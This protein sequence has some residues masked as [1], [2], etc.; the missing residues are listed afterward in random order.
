MTI[1]E[2]F[3]LKG[4]ARGNT[5]GKI[6]VAVNMLKNNMPIDQIAELTDLE[7]ELVIKL[8][9]DLKNKSH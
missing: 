3:E 8:S 6:E 1:A 5:N 9:E 4:E 2:A 7:K